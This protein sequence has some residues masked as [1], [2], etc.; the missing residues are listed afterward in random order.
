MERK[1]VISMMHP[2]NTMRNGTVNVFKLTRG[3]EKFIFGKTAPNS[4]MAARICL[5]SSGNANSSTSS[6]SPSLAASASASSILEKIRVKCQVELETLKV[7][8]YRPLPLE[9]ARH[10]RACIF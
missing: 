9:C 2:F 5:S 3:E 10:Q 7:R 1:V 4:S 8:T 6:S